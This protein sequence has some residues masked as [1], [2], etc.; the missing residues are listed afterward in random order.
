MFT[1]RTGNPDSPTS[2]RVPLC[3]LMPGAPWGPGSP[4]RPGGPRVPFHNQTV[5]PH[6]QTQ[7]ILK[8]KLLG[9]SPFWVRTH[10]SNLGK[11]R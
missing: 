6:K 4:G 5:S 1:W 9:H 11:S 10:L 8:T 2:P 7:E 3:P